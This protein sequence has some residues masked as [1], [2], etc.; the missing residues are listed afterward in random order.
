MMA[1][2]LRLTML[3]VTVIIPGGFLLLTFY[4]AGRAQPRGPALDFEA[5]RRR[6]PRLREP[7]PSG[8]RTRRLLRRVHRAEA[9]SL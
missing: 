2:L 5:G 1:T 8:A 7:P 9:A 3:A 6:V 4:L